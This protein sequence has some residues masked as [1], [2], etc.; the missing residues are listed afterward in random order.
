MK[1]KR[2]CVC[3]VR[4]SDCIFVSACRFVNDIANDSVYYF[5]FSPSGYHTTHLET[6]K[7]MSVI[8]KIE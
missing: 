5:L 8:K 7:W 6:M 1:G 4:A 3:C 2:V